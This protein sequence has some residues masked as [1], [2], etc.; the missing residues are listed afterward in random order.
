MVVLVK[1]VDGFKGVLVMRFFVLCWYKVKLMFKWF[2]NSWVLILNLYFVCSLGLRLGLFNVVVVLLF[3][4]N[5]VLL[6]VVIIVFVWLI[7][8]WV[9]EES[10]F[11][12]LYGF[13]KFVEVLKFICNFKKFNKLLE[14]NI[15]VGIKDKLVLG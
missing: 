10:V 6:L 1:F 4:K 3:L 5:V 9:L 15:F 13:G 2:L 12:V 8:W 7:N 14:L 11:L